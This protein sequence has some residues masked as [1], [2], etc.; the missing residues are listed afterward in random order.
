[1][2]I[3]SLCSPFFRSE[4]KPHDSPDECVS[5]S[6]AQP[7]HTGGPRRQATMHG[8]LLVRACEPAWTPA[9]PG[10]RSNQCRWCCPALL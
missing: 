10:N 1:M 9:P 8:C 7:A 2:I 5:S 4:D 6:E 3:K